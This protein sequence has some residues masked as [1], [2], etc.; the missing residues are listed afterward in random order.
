MDK[1]QTTDLKMMI[2][3]TI[4]IQY[5]LSIAKK[6]KKIQKNIKVI[7]ECKESD[8]IDVFKILPYSIVCNK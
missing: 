3:Y 6:K 1:Y 4:L 7:Q 2:I 8:S 5:M